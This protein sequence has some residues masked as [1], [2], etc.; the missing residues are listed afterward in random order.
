MPK[1]QRLY[2]TL[3]IDIHRHPKLRNQPAEVKWAFVEM[4]I[5]AII[6]GNDGR[7]SAEDAEFLW[8]LEILDA[9]VRTHPSRPLVYRE[10]DGG[11]YVIR[12]FAEHQMTTADRERR[13]AVS[14]ANGAKGGRPRKNPGGTQE[15]PG[16]V[17]TGTQP[18]PAGTRTKAESESESEDFFSRPKSQS[19]SNRASVSTDSMEVPEL[20][21]QMAARKG[22]SSLRSVA[23]AV[24]RATGLKVDATGAFRVAAWICE[25]PK[26]WPK[27]PQRYVTGSIVQS[28]F[29]VQQFIHEQA[30]EVAS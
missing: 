27:S 9:L 21:R 16:Q 18:E 5:E 20:T 7:F 29:E 26:E 25:K 11:D 15:K 30:L 6:A 22:I 2:I 10:K 24:H 3:P 17:P 23:D 8:P 1:D 19:S 13:A 28:P 14:R 12:E 4:N